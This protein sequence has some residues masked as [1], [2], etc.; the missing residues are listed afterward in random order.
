MANSY[1]INER[2]ISNLYDSYLEIG[3]ADGANFKNINIKNKIWV[4]PFPQNGVEPYGFCCTSDY[5]FKSIVPL[6]NY[7]FDLIFVDGW[8]EYRQCIRDILNSLKILND[9]GMIIVH[10]TYPTLKEHTYQNSST[11]FWTGD[12]WKAIVDIRM[13]RSDLIFITYPISA[14]YTLITRGSGKILELDNSVES[15]TWEDYVENKDYYLN[16]QK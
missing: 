2:I 10:D 1:F 8:H 16:V 7:K 12:V 13:K 5:F 9:M 4:D 14:G 3:V 11:S 15:L 6:H